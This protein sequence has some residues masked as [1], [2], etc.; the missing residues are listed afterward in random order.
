MQ[1]TDCAKRKSFVSKSAWWFQIGGWR[2]SFWSLHSPRE[3][4]VITQLARVW[5][6][7]VVWMRGV[8]MIAVMGFELEGTSVLSCSSVMWPHRLTDTAL[9]FQG[10]PTMQRLAAV[11][12]LVALVGSEGNMIQV[13]TC[14]QTI[15]F[16]FPE[17]WLDGKM[18]WHPLHPYGSRYTPGHPIY[19]I[20]N[21]AEYEPTRMEL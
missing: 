11:N 21:H 2:S 3:G 12:G 19:G 17:I 1:N 20:V 10:S 14:K 7:R 8:Q 9:C 15:N 6:D 13:R 18:E 4:W 5:H 16:F